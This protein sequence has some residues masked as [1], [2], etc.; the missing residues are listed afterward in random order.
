[1]T[2]L[3]RLEKALEKIAKVGVRL[4]RDRFTKATFLEPTTELRI[5]LRQSYIV[6]ANVVSANLDLK[7]ND[8]MR[9]KYPELFR[10][11]QRLH[12]R[13]TI[14]DHKYEKAGGSAEIN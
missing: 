3:A 9:R 11:A 1:M 13:C 12:G 10:Q 7:L 14:L 8:P 5:R 6:D 4:R 2:S